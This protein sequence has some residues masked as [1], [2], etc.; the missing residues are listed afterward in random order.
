MQ[1]LFD[2]LWL[3]LQSL[4]A[5]LSHL[6]LFGLLLSL[7]CYQAGLLIYQ[8]VGRNVILHP[9]VTASL[10][11]AL[12]L[13]LLNIPY[14]EYLQANQLLYFLLGPA[15]VALAIPLYQEFHHIRRLALPILVT[16]AMGAT[17][18]SVSAVAIAYWLGGSETTLLSLA[19]KSVTTPIALGVSENIGGLPALTTG[20]VVFTGV[21]GTLLSPVVFYLLRLRDPRQQGIVLG[22][23]AHGVGTARGFEINA[24]TGAFASLAMGMTGAFTA[25]TLPYIVAALRAAGWL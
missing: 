9:V 2:S 21:I 25:L 20:V 19:P 8:R 7:L 1:S 3:Q 13:N 23:N 14:K 5:H 4:W 15:T 16:V 22:I 10:A 12:L 11:I 6:P 18:A 24:S 17:F